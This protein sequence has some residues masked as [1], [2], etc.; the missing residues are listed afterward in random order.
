MTTTTRQDTK[1]NALS[2]SGFVSP[3]D[4]AYYFVPVSTVLECVSTTLIRSDN[5]GGGVGGF[6]E[7]IMTPPDPSV[8]EEGRVVSPTFYETRKD[9]LLSRVA[10]QRRRR[11]SKES[12]E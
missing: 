12:R 4:A 5:D 10:R 11:K 1:L 6:A 8:A 2:P 9:D 3:E 7:C